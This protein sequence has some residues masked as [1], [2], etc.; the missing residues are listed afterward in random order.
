[1]SVLINKEIGLKYSLWNLLMCN[2][3]LIVEFLKNENLF[4]LLIKDSNIAYE[5][6]QN[7]CY[8]I[9]KNKINEIQEQLDYFTKLDIS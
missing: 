9:F 7:K 5:L 3:L 8:E 2:K 4:E 1:M 6:K